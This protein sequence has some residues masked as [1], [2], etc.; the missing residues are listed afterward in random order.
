MVA[1]ASAQEPVRSVGNGCTFRRDLVSSEDIRTSVLYLADIVAS[2]LRQRD[3]KCRT[4]S[5]AIKD[6]VLKSITR[7]TTL[8]TPAYLSRDISGAALALIAR[9]W[10]G[11]QPIRA[12]TVTAENLMPAPLAE[13]RQLTLFPETAVP[14]FERA[15]RF[16]KTIDLICGKYGR[17][18][19]QS[20]RS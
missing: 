12:L 4:I 10:A 19:V 1:A 11:S 9:H 8:K 3:L 2:R 15:E 5:A 7:Q 17:H 6:A 18:S 14:R 16:E 20:R 13:E